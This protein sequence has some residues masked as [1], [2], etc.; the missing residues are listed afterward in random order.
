M[1]NDSKTFDD[2]CGKNFNNDYNNQDDNNCDKK[3]ITFWEFLDNVLTAKKLFHVEDKNFPEAEEL[4][5]LYVCYMF[6]TLYNIDYNELLLV[7]IAIINEAFQKIAE[8]ISNEKFDWKTYWE[9]TTKNIMTHTIQ[10]DKEK[11]IE[12]FRITEEIVLQIFTEKRSF[13]F[14]QKYDRKYNLQ[15]FYKLY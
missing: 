4:L 14:I 7:D 2:N 15:T 5:L 11:L 6:E 13:E 10:Y 1:E 3:I 12:L 8:N 9:E